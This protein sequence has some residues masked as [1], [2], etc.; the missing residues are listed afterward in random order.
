MEHIESFCT[1][2]SQLQ[3]RSICSIWIRSRTWDIREFATP[4]STYSALVHV[5]S[6]QVNCAPK[7]TRP[8]VG[9]Y[10][11]AVQ[12]GTASDDFP[13]K[14]NLL[15][16]REKILIEHIESICSWDS[17][18]FFDSLYSI[19]IRSRNGDIF[20]KLKEASVFEVISVSRPYSYRTY[21][22]DL[23]PRF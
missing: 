11:G 6:I 4:P 23:W 3:I 20:K 12:F 13:K 9:P 14:L 5:V 15:I 19:R 17:E 1:L 21:R 2:K 16:F 7:S 18:L 22:V 10:C 8:I